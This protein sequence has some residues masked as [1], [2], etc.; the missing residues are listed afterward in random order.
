MYDADDYTRR[1]FEAA[2]GVKL[3]DKID[4]RLPEREVRAKSSGSRV[5]DRLCLQKRERFGGRELAW[6]GT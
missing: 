3:A 2:M 1:Y 6:L 5:L 4:V